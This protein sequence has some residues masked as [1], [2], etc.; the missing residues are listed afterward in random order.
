MIVALTC[1]CVFM[2]EPDVNTDTMLIGPKEM[3]VRGRLY[4][5]ALVT[6]PISACRGLPLFG[7]ELGHVDTRRADGFSTTPKN[8]SWFASRLTRRRNPC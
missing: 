2:L 5:V 7:T 4:K 8:R 1:C 3:V 6:I